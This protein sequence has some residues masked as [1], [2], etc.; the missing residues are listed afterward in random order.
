MCGQSLLSM[1]LEEL[2]VCWGALCACVVWGIGGT[3]CL[4]GEPTVHGIGGAYG[5]SGKPSDHGGGLLS[6]ELVETL[7]VG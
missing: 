3:P 2:M 1:E 6:M 4:W 5:L 7:S